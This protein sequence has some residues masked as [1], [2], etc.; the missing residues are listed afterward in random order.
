VLG[1]S[2]SAQANIGHKWWGDIVTEPW[3]LNE[4]T[5]VSEKLSIDL[6]PLAACE[7]A[8]V[9]V[10]YALDNV[11]PSRKLDLVF[12]SGETGISD[13]EAR[14]DDKPLAA[15]MLPG[16]E[17]RRYWDRVPE[18]WRPP[19]KVP[20]FEEHE[21]Y[22]MFGDWIDKA[23]PVE[24][25]VELP[26]GASAL[27]VRYRARACGTDEGHPTATWQFPY[28]LAPA[29]EW[30]GFGRLDVTVQLPEQ[31]EARTTS[32]LKRDGDELR[33]S[34]SGLPSDALLLA[35]RAPVP[36]DF[37]RAKKLSAAIYVGALLG[38]GVLCGWLGWRK[39]RRA[40]LL[41]VS[42][43]AVP[44]ANA[45]RPL[46]L[47]IVLAIVWAGLVYAAVTLV[48]GRLLIASLHGQESPD[49]HQRLGWLFVSLC[50]AIPVTLLLG[51]LI[52]LKSAAIAEWRATD[53]LSRT[54]EDSG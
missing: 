26:T 36:P 32:A 51:P 43:G 20:G 8:M 35:T 48:P 11:G 49:Y 9:E 15:R 18:S 4:V 16:R 47:A 22:C 21:T 13:F 28:I 54:A 30:G 27:W 31:W 19:R 6:R 23:V 37:E 25:S 1:I 50:C 42:A 7:P 29:R 40:A 10:G 3:G 12:V 52:T 5:I 41:A 45:S 2:P 46:L 44:G 33:G 17:L 38:G 24:F 53:S 14:L 34:F 39:G